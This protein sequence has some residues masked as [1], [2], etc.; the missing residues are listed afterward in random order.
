[1]PQSMG[2]GGPSFAF[3]FRGGPGQPLH[4]LAEADAAA[5]KTD[6][7]WVHLDLRDTGRKLGYPAVPGRATS[8]RR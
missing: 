6:F 3:V 2:D 8:S 5:R 4:D 1:M 7:V